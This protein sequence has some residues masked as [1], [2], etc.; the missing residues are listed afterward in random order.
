MDI[1]VFAKALLDGDDTAIVLCDLNHTIVYMNPFAIN[2]YHG[3]LTGQTLM[4][5]HNPDS[6]AKIE[7]TIAWFKEDKS[8]NRV[9]EFHNE[10]ENRDGYMVALRDEKGELIGYWE[11]HCYR[12]V[13][14]EPF[15][16]YK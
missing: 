5:C 9:L 10:K 11:K 15:Y 3:D 8:H 7:R 6:R 2:K 12:N 1:S 14:T 4:A 13:E 16:N